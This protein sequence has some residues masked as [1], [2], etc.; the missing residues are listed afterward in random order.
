MAEESLTATI[1]RG[2]E[3]FADFDVRGVGMLA[4]APLRTENDKKIVMPMRFIEVPTPAWYPDSFL[5]AMKHDLYFNMVNYS[6][7]YGEKLSNSREGGAVL[8]FYKD[9]SSGNFLEN[10]ATSA[11][12][13]IVTTAANQVMSITGKIDSVKNGVTSFLNSFGSKGSAEGS[14]LSD[15]TTMATDPFLAAQPYIKING[16]HLAEN[17]RD[18]YTVIRSIGNIMSVAFSNLSSSEKKIEFKDI[19]DTA[20]DSFKNALSFLGISQEKGK[21]MNKDTNFLKMIQDYLSN[22]DRRMH[23]FSEAQML[24]SISGYYTMTCKLPFFGNASPSFQSCGEDSIGYDMGSDFGAEETGLMALANKYIS[25]A[26]YKPIEWH[27]NTVFKSTMTPINYS[28]NIFNDTIEHALL[29]LAFIFSFGA[30]TQAVT[31]ICTVRP[32]Y[33]YDVVVPGGLRFKYCKCRFKVYPQ[34]KMRKIMD[35]GGKDGKSGTFLKEIFKSV[36]GFNINP[37]AIAYVPDYYKITMVFQ[38]ALPNLWNFVDSYLHD[39]RTVPVTGEA[40]RHLLA[41]TVQNFADSFAS[42]VQNQNITQL[43][44]GTYQKA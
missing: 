26:W 8:D 9:S 22:G 18:A 19:L 3:T 41:S 35:L 16:I 25:F 4:Q 11:L 33:L 40:I 6:S 7:F 15:M 32:P 14:M 42:A 39:E 13:S 36:F 21:E 34:G 20:W 17:I 37:E 38:S 28:F 5:R 23:N 44:Y 43:G 29:N 31:D 12:K 24:S 30:T 2:I 10:L 1:S 27:Q